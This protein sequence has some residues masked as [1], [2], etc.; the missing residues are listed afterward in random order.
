MTTTPRP[1][2]DRFRQALEYAATLHESQARKCTDIPYIAH[3]VA[4]A[5]IVLEY[6]GDEDQ[7]IAA[8]LHDAIEDQGGDATRQEI[9]TGLE[10]SRRLYG[11]IDLRVRDCAPCEVG[12]GAARQQDRKVLER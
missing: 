8:L 9:R 1:L 12:D 3:L 10:E 11:R 2:G 7:A 6:G 4:V 5:A